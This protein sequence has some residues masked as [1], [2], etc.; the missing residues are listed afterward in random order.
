MSIVHF[1]SNYGFGFVLA[2]LP[3]YLVSEQ[4]AER[5]PEMTLLATL[6]Y[7]AQAVAAFTPGRFPDR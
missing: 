1:A 6:G 5:S 4:G 3:L 2:W 7:A